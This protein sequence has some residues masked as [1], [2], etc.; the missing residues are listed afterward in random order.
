MK[1]QNLKDHPFPLNTIPICDCTCHKIGVQMLHC[2]ACCSLVYRKYINKDGSLNIEAYGK[3]VRGDIKYKWPQ[4]KNDKTFGE[5][6]ELAD[7][8]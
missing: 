1:F 2:V 7:G 4:E 6:T 8:A 3:A 5:V